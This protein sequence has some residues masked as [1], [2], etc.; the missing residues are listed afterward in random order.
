M[1]GGLTTGGSIGGGMN[2]DIALF[3]DIDV[4]F[5]SL[6]ESKKLGSIAGKFTPFAALEKV[7]NALKGMH[8]VIALSSLTLTTSLS[9][10]V[11]PFGA[12]AKIP[13]IM[14]RKG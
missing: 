11:T 13:G 6:Q 14:S 12:G 2:I 5:E 9:P 7:A 3:K 8:D 10:P 1:T 4:S